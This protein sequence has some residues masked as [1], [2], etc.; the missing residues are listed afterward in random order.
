MRREKLLI[1][2][3]MVILRPSSKILKL[4]IQTLTTELTP[5]SDADK[6]VKMKKVK[7]ISKSWSLN[8]PELKRKKRVAGYKI[9]AAEGKMKGSLKKS[10]RWIK[11][12]YTQ[13]INGWW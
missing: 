3:L 4:Q 8:D 6:E 11:S 9:Y 7:G 2:K 12:T 13:A 10:L 1:I 5:H